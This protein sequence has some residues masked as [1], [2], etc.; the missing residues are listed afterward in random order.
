M[1][2]YGS[3]PSTPYLKFTVTFLLS[4]NLGYYI[5][6]T[7][8]SVSLFTSVSVVV[9][10]CKYVCTI[11]IYKNILCKVNHQRETC[12][13]SVNFTVLYSVQ[14]YCR[15]VCMFFFNAICIV[16]LN[17]DFPI[18]TI[19]ATLTCLWCKIQYL[20]VQCFSVPV[21]KKSINSRKAVIRPLLVERFKLRTCPIIPKC[22]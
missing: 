19:T 1:S 18:N 12:F 9:Y 4:I 11:C 6:P 13:V 14:M 22:V 3:G 5:K 16:I 15:V 17:N 7:K 21:H 10:L 8:H 2:I 20:W